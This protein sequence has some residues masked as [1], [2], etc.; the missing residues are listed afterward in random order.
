ME[1]LKPESK[2]E[3]GCPIC[4]S[5]MV[6][7]E[8]GEF[9]Q[10]VKCEARFPTVFDSAGFVSYIQEKFEIDDNDLLLSM[11]TDLT[12]AELGKR[13]DDALRFNIPKGSEFEGG[14]SM[15]LDTPQSEKE[16]FPRSIT[17]PKVTQRFVEIKANEPN[18]PEKMSVET[19]APKP[20]TLE[21][22]AGADRIDP[23]IPVMKATDNTFKREDGKKRSK[24]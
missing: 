17:P 24:D 8:M 7:M 22:C 1:V 11:R 3:F 23:D 15:S 16:P 13:I 2:K 18:L 6:E 10:C 20:P 19:L 12:D 4:G 5:E 21:G 9:H 14:P